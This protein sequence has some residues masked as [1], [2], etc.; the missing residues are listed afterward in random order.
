MPVA[1]TRARKKL[2][3]S[4]ACAELISASA[5]ARRGVPSRRSRAVLEA[6]PSEGDLHLARRYLT[7]PKSR[8]NF[9]H[10]GRST[11]RRPIAQESIAVQPYRLARYVPLARTG[12]QSI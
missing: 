3:L 4:S 2:L 11:C 7:K 12:I 10:S 6:P 9:T 5:A 8:F 1:V